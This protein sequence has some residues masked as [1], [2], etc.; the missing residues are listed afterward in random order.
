MYKSLILAAVLLSLNAQAS[1]GSTLSKSTNSGFVAPGYRTATKCEIYSDKVVLT[2]SAEGVQS[3]QERKITLKG[4]IDKAIMDAS[5]GLIEEETAPSDG[6]ELVYE[7]TQILP[8]DAML[9]VDLGSYTGGDGKRTKN[10]SAAAR[11]L[12]NFLDLNC[13]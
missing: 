2:L 3:V 1:N 6:P 12:R 9:R 8:N 5:K 11:G 7:A 13:N 10:E 4:A